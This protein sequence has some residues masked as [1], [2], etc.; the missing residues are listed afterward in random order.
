MDTQVTFLNAHKSLVWSCDYIL[1]NEIEVQ[2]FLTRI[3]ESSKNLPQKKDSWH[4]FFITFLLFF[5]IFNYP[6]I[7]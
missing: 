2:D 6:D 5:L 3:Q 1:A 4:I 7:P